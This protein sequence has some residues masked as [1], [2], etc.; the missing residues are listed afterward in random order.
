[1]FQNLS[2]TMVWLGE[3]EQAGSIVVAH[4]GGRFDFLFRDYLMNDRLVNLKKTK[5]PILKGN[6]IV[7]ATLHNDITLIDSYAFVTAPLCKFPG[8]FNIEEEK[9]GFFPHSFNRPEFWNYVGP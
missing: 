5:N 4:C 9:K 7:S 2:D 6:K 8:I 1:M 3:K